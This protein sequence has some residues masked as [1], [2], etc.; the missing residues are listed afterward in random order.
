MGHPPLNI[1]LRICFQVILIKFIAEHQVEIQATDV[2]VI[3]ECEQELRVLSY[4]NCQFHRKVPVSKFKKLGVVCCGVGS[5]LYFSRPAFRRLL[6][7]INI[8]QPKKRPVFF[9]TLCSA[10]Q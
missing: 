10:A 5:D 1:A 8:T 4:S 9:K 2:P 6:S 3:V 7:I